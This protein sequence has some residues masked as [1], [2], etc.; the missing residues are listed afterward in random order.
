MLKPKKLHRFTQMHTQNY[1]WMNSLKSI[2]IIYVRTYTGKVIASHKLRIM[3]L[4]V[5][6]S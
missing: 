1:T 6:P 3:T 5:K 2:D 4:W